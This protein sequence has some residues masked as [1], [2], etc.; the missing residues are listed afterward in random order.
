MEQNPETG[1]DIWV[2]NLADRKARPFLNTS[3]EEAAPKFSP[4]GNWL[5]YSSDETG[6][7]EVYAQ[8]YPGPGGKW[9]ISTDGGQEPVW[10]PKGGELFYRSGNKVMAVDIDATSGFSPGKPRMLFQGSYLQTPAS[11]P[12]YDVSP[13]GER[14]LMLK[15]VEQSSAPTHINVVLNWLEELKQKSSAK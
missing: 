7:R 8:P 6:R 4:D 12:Y 5:L 3:Y 2:L 15:P 14:F 13:D 9:Q 10:N 1:R 11:F